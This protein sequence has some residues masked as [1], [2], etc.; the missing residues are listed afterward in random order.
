MLQILA[1]IYSYIL[2]MN[3]QFYYYK[4]SSLI[5][6]W[7]K[8]LTA[9]QETCVQSLGCEDALEKE[10]ETQSSILSWRIP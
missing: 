10:M 9:M 6:Q 4:M 2:F 7:V 8:S 5:A 3:Q 1:H